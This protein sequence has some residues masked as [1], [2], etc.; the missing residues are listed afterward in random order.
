MARKFFGTD[1]IR[2]RT[3]VGVMTAA[4]A[5]KVGQAA[6][7]YFLRGQ[8]RHRVVI[9]KDTRLSGYMLENA[10]TAGFTSVG[11][12]VVLLGP[13]PTPAVALLT[14]E[15]RADVG[16]MISASHNPYE[17]N[18]IKLFGPD[19]F[20]LSDEDELAIEAMLGEELELAASEDVGR[21]RRIDDA[22][23][24][25]IHAVKASL[26]HNVRLDG[27][28]IVVDCANGAAYHVAPSALWEL[29]A[30]VIAIGVEPN[31]KNINAGVG[32][33]HLDAIKA[34][35]REVRADI[36]LALDGD[37]DRLIVVDEKG[38]TVDGDQI[39]ALIGS[40]LAA[41]GELR[42]GG[43]VAT[44]MS[45]LGLE[46]FLE[47]QGLALVRTA[48]GDRHVLEK[49]REGGFNVGGEQSGHMILTDHGTTGDGTVA[50][51]QVLAALIASG[52]PASET[53]HLFDP[54]PQLLKNVRFSG[55]KP[56]EA[57]SVKAVI[58]QVEAQLQGRGR[59]VIRPS[60]TEPVIR[61]MAEADDAAEVEDVVDRICEAV[62][63]AAA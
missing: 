27:L 31:G 58:A 53:L 61:V 37:A 55:G 29:G 1:G 9:G 22:R 18:G 7:T 10:M 20:K 32:S 56:L 41:R 26:P 63:K 39:M 60:G 17:D 44:V 48:V 21:A 8:H 50:A 42:G 28:R 36:G 2:G 59:L 16:V 46:R 52:K 11:M 49:M 23:G 12:D 62:R 38:Q 19:G 51:L 30:E 40:Q 24:R 3:N 54:V 57:E 5:M 47:T 35:V 15:M 25:Y 43:V 13:M 4:T 45:N 34:K 6:G 14:R 33:T